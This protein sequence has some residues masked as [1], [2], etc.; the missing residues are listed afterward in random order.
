MQLS[1]RVHQM[2]SDVPMG[3]AYLNPGSVITKMIARMVLMKKIVSTHHVLLENLLV[4]T[5]DVFQCRR[6]NTLILFSE[7]LEFII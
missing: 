3:D 2:N 4:P 5:I 7:K 1:T 6:Y